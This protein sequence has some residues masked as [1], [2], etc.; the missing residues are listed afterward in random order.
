[1]NRLD[2][3]LLTKE[4]AKNIVLDSYKQGYGSIALGRKDKASVFFKEALG[5]EKIKSPNSLELARAYYE[6]GMIACSQD[7]F[8]EAFDN[9]KQAITIIEKKDPNS[10]RLSNCFYDTGLAFQKGKDLP[11]ALECFQKSLEIAK[12]KAPN[13]WDVINA[14]SKMGEV[15]ESQ[16]DLLQS[17]N[18]YSKSLLAQESI[19]EMRGVNVRN[20]KAGYERELSRLDSYFI[21]NKSTTSIINDGIIGRN[22]ARVAPSE[23]NTPTPP[24]TNALY[25]RLF[26]NAS[27]VMP[28]NSSSR[29]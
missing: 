26:G 16:G 18:Y 29:G 24:I 6:V 22:G 20:I 9:L 17:A 3:F 4:K 5:I 12:D 21:I 2:I 15:Y 28:L 10:L 23:T 27:K 7:D 11:A 14:Y 13:S 19:E 25:K 1:M 8:S